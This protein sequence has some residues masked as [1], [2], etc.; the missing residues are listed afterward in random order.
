MQWFDS[1][2][3]YNAITQNDFLLTVGLG[4][5]A[6]GMAIAI[7]WLAKY[8]PSHIM[9]IHRT[10]YVVIVQILVLTCGV[11]GITLLSGAYGAGLFVAISVVVGATLIFFRPGLISDRLALFQSRQKTPDE[12]SSHVEPEIESTIADNQN[13]ISVVSA[14]DGLATATDVAGVQ[15]LRQDDSASG[16]PRNDAPEQAT[17]LALVDAIKRTPLQPL[18]KRPTLGRRSIREL[19]STRR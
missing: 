2:L 1:M 14:H 19:H 12:E 15:T 4:I 5:L 16:D 17:T 8:L 6:I 3:R 7:G 10:I 18:V 11:A 9:R 13:A